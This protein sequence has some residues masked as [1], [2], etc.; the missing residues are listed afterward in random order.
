MALQG[1]V[2]VITGASSGIGALTAQML[3]QR[4]AVP[5]LLA[6]SEDKLKE[7]AAGIPGVFGLFV[8]DVTDEA[9]VERTFAEILEQY[10]RIDILLNNAGYGK[11]AAFTE[12]EPGEFDAMMDVNYM[13]IVRC[14]KAVVPH[15]LER[16][17]GQIVNVASMAGKIGTAR[18]VAY[19]ATKHAVLGFTN[20]L[21]QELR[22]SGII[23]SA[24]NPGPIATEFFKTADPSGNYEKSV[25]RIMMTPQHVSAK[26]VKLMDKGKEEVDLPGLAAFGIRL[27]GLFPRL[28]DKL[29]YN[30]MNR[31]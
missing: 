21:R 26:I 22:K 18:A 12:M 10:G 6:R 17:S 8:C 3:S 11:F 30:A 4:G 13:G 15:M 23:V 28:A 5:I 16:G 27:Y 2:V 25:S 19:T 9:A 20:A 31:K 7:T 24:V 1:K 14:T 29:T